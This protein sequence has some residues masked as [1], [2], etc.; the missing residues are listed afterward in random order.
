MTGYISIYRKG[1]ITFLTQG[2][3]HLV[4]STSNL[5]IPIQNLSIPSFLNKQF[6]IC[7]KN[8]YFKV[9]L[10]SKQYRFKWVLVVSY[11]WYYCT[12]LF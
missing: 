4:N 10:T 3:F 8:T 9:A 12:P 6:K 5:S 2:Q 7:F 11:L 1:F